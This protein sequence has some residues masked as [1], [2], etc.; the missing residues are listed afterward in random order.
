MKEEQT[1][2]QV[3]HE[4]E[5]AYIDCRTTF[6]QDMVREG[7]DDDYIKGRLEWLD[8]MYGESLQSVQNILNTLEG[9]GCEI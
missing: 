6:I 4:L 8:E 2:E 5:N 9:E 1:D 3:R 7:R